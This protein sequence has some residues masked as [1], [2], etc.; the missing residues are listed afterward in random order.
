[1]NNYSILD[2][3]SDSDLN[4]VKRAYKKMAMKYHPDKNNSPDAAEKFQEISKAYNNIINPETQLDINN[5]FNDIFGDGYS[6]AFDN[7][8]NLGNLGNLFNNNFN[9]RV[10]TGKDVFKMVYISLEELY[11]KS[12]ININ[13]DTQIINKIAKKCE[14]CNGQGKIQSLQH[15][16]PIV[17]QSQELCDICGGSGFDN[18]YL[19][20]NDNYELNI[21]NLI[22]LNDIIIPEKGIPIL[23]GKNGNLVITFRLKEH[24]YLKLKGNDLYTNMTISLKES[25]TGF[26]KTISQLDKR[27]ITI[28]S[29]SIIKPNTVK[30]IKQEG[31]NLTE[32]IGNL[33]IKFKVIYPDSLSEKQIEIVNEYF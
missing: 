4:T 27:F 1:M 5:I 33:Y 8:G 13:Y 10:P 2:I 24:P 12:I 30:C 17:I 26:T 14:K 18:L 16:G 32:S 9:K 23:N 22:N 25:L 21:D 31:L 3:D 11:N 19:H 20:K 6:G 28:N 29:D 7:F 15:L